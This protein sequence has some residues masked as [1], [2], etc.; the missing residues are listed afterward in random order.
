MGGITN[1]ER[2]ANAIIIQAVK[3]YRVALKGLKA[4]K[5]NSAARSIKRKVER[6]FRSEWFEMLTDADGEK[7]LRSLKQEVEE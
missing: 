4:D 2:L 1:Y 3:D 5:K 6:F 7:L